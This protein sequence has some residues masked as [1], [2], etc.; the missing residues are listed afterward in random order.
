VYGHVNNVVY[1]QWMDTTIN[2]FLISQAGFTPTQDCVVGYCVASGCV[3]KRSVA[4]PQTVECGLRVTKL[5]RSSVRYEVGI[6]SGEGSSE[7]AALGY[8]V[9]VFVDRSTERPTPIPPHVLLALKKLH[10]P[11]QG[12]VLAA[13]GGAQ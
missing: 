6:F 10:A 5:G 3:F 7:M 2:H 4:F 11:S 12:E 8:F 9:H 1:Y 13:A